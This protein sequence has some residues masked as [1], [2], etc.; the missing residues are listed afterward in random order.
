MH[1]VLAR[2]DH[3]ALARRQAIGL[4]HQGKM[5]MRQGLVNIVQGTADGIVRRGNVV[6]LHEFLGET[7]ARFELR[8][9]L[10][11]A[12]DAQAAPGEFIDHPRLERNFRSHH[13]QIRLNPV[14]H[15]E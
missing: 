13:G 6:A 11:G 8:R 5:K 12:E 4:D 9:R 10:G 15:G 3:H 7:L 1:L 14:R 2:A